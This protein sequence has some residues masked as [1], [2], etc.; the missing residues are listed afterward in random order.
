MNILIL[1]VICIEITVVLSAVSLFLS[2]LIYG[3]RAEW[4]NYNAWN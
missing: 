4:Q 2:T 3:L 1:A